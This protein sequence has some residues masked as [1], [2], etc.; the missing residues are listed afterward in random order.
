MLILVNKSFKKNV[1]KKIIK[2]KTENKKCK[3]DSNF[4][5]FLKKLKFVN[6]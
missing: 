3:G 6:F 1:L 4:K 5:T 2:T